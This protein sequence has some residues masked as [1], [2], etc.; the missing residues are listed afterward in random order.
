MKRTCVDKQEYHGLHYL[1]KKQFLEQLS[2]SKDI[3]NFSYNIHKEPLH[4]NDI[5]F[6]ILKNQIT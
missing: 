3:K 4:T 6:I 2:S 5:F 1:P